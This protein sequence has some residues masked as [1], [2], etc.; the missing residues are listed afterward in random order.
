MAAFYIEQTQSVSSPSVL[1]RMK[2]VREH[3]ATEHYFSFENF[4]APCGITVYIST[5][6][7][8]KTQTA[9]TQYCHSVSV[10]NEE[11]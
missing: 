1:H 11:M 5:T 4:L 9:C 3:G 6:I 10:K 8:L 7:Y 2:H